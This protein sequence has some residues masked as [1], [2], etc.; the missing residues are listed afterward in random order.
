MSCASPKR[1]SSKSSLWPG[2]GSSV[3]F[4]I[5]LI[6]VLLDV[7]LDVL[8]EVEDLCEGAG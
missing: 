6:E 7:L 8:V 2:C 1:E 5:A 4:E 3:V